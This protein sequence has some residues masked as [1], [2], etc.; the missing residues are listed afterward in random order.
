MHRVLLVVAVL[1]LLACGASA[2]GPAW[3]KQTT[4]EVDGG[5]SLAPRSSVAAVDDSDDVA[6]IKPD[7]VEPKSEDKPK[8]KDTKPETPTGVKPAATTPDEPATTEEIVIEVED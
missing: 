4:K 8:A 5:E 7:A 1:G 6:E 3:P 2:K